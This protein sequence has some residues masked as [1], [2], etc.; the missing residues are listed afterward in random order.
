MGVGDEETDGGRPPGEEEALITPEAASEI[1]AAEKRGALPALTDVGSRGKAEGQHQEQCVEERLVASTD[2]EGQGSPAVPVAAGGAVT[3]GHPTHVFVS[4]GDDGEPHGRAVQVQA[5]P[6]VRRSR[7]R[8]RGR[9]EEDAVEGIWFDKTILRVGARVPWGRLH[10][11]RFAKVSFPAAAL[12]ERRSRMLTRLDG[13]D[14][15]NTPWANLPGAASM[16]GQD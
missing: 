7:R 11:G 15:Q 8:A 2:V 3:T 1:L 9:L 5:L 6:L 14:G 4:A 10:R 16:A 12:D 13:R